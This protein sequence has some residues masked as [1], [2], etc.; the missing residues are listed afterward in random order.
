MQIIDAVI[1]YTH[2]CTLTGV[3][4]VFGG[5]EFVWAIISLVIVFRIGYASTRFLAAAF[6]IYNLLGWIVGIS[7]VAGSD[8][9]STP[10]EL[11]IFMWFVIVGGIFGLVYSASSIY[12]RSKYRLFDSLR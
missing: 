11:P 7:L 6:V 8:M 1:L 9:Q 12:L 10:S 2:N 4:Y 3:S 5:I